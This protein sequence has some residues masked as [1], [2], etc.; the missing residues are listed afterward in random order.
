MINVEKI[1]D[2]TAKYYDKT[3]EIRFKQPNIKVIEK[4][5]KYLKISDVVL[6]YGCATGTKATKL[7]GKVKKIY[8]IDISSKMI[9]AA[10]RKAVERKIENVDFAQATIFD[11]RYKRESF[12]VILAFNILHLLEDNRQPIQK[13]T[14][15]LKPGGLFIS[16]TPCLGE[17]MK[18]ST[19]FQFSFFLLLSIIGLFP[20]IKRFKFPELEDLIADGNLQIVEIEKSYHEMSSCF[21]VTKK[22]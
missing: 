18:F 3:E 17:K 14:E 7:A 9:E 22:I 13:I 2:L 10:K 21:I 19:K 6:D 4:T 12:D 20:S 11:E 5:K 1:F 8:A 16:T 15:L